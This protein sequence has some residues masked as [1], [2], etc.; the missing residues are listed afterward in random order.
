MVADGH[1]SD[2][3]VD[4]IYSG[5]VSLRGFRFL[6]FLAEL[7]GLETWGTDISSALQQG[8]IGGCLV[9][10]MSVVN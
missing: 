6:L 8:T 3:P 9:F 4:G 1:L 10:K 7:N 5:G 2:I